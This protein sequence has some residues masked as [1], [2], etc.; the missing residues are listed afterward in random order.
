MRP[1]PDTWPL[2]PDP[3]ALRR[4]IDACADYVVDHVATLPE[5]H[6]GDTDGAAALAATFREPVPETGRA[7]EEILARL[8]PAVLKSFNT[9]GPGYLAFIPGGGLPTVALAD[10]IGLVANRYVGMVAPS[11]ALA[12]IE[13]TAIEWLAAIMGYGPGSGGILTSGGSLSNLSAVVAARAAKLPED[14]LHGTLYISGEAHNSVQKAARTAGFPERCIRRVPTDARLR[15]RADELEKLVVAD[16]A[17]GLR[18]FL[19]VANVGSTNTGAIDP[20]P[21][22]LEVASRHDLWVHADAAYGGFFRIAPGGEALMPGIERCDSITLDPHKGL[23]F[24]YGTG[25]LLVR[26]RESLRR[27]Y[28][29]AGAYLQDITGGDEPN[30]SDISPELSREFRGLR[31]WLPLQLHGLEPFRRQLGE[32]LELTRWAYGQLKDDP[33]FEMLDEPQMSVVAFSV[34]APGRDQAALGAEILRRVNARGRVYL[35]ST[36]IAGR[37]VLRICV[38]SFRTH[39]E[40][41]RDA[42]ESLKEEARGLLDS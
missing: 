23:F 5:Q 42:V 20:L 15:M 26:E 8:K 9:A 11:P 24:P 13:A 21:S 36:S 3:E 12:R 7:L 40:R 16:R 2:E 35:S 30:F 37:Y 1:T 39:I 41:V 32:K 6:A 29:V 22:I 19:V 28:R 38:L 14:F 34:R 33:H 31:V 27:P 17:A 4:M 25:C 18:P 10:F